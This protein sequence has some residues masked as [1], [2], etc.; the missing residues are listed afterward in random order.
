MPVFPFNL[1]LHFSQT[2]Y[3]VD[4]ILSCEQQ[5]EIKKNSECKSKQVLDLLATQD[6][7]PVGDQPVCFILGLCAVLLTNLGSV[8]KVRTEKSWN[9]LFHGYCHH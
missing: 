7:E 6:Q 4:E 5:A 1:N 2:G 8:C 9:T 3:I